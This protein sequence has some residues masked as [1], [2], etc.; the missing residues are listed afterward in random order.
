[1]FLDGGNPDETRQIIS[2]LGFLDGQTTNPTLIAKNPDAR[3]RLERGEKFSAQEITEFYKGVV[4][5][6]SGLI[7]QGSVSVEVYADARTPSDQMVS[8]GTE[9]FS[10]IPNAH[11]KFPSTKE[12]LG[13]AEQ[14]IRRGLRVNMTL[15]FT[16][17]QAAAVYSATV[18]AKKGDVFV[19]PFVG[20]LDDRGEDGMDLIA[21]V[22][23]MYRTGDSHVEVLTASVR[24]MDHF[25]YALRL[26]SDIITAP[27][28][29]LK[30]W[31]QKGLPIPEEDYVHDAKSLTRIPY[32]TI[33]IGR[34]WSEYDI[35]HELTDKGMEL[36][37][38]DWNNLIA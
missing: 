36:F 34:S 16:Q 27:F 19:S 6:I 9:M 23:T 11:I 33:D 35:A 1:M 8:Q 28:A 15:C 18:G 29:I 17:E 32:K 30:E 10:W 7:P 25:L 4:K 2:L 31:G 26:G 38:R 13:A 12:G 14:A 5:E 24:T 37:S 21:N 20:R 3:A 22:L